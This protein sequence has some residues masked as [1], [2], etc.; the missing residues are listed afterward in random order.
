LEA[1]EAAYEQ[2]LAG[3]EL[4]ELLATA[5]ED[6]ATA[7]PENGDFGCLSPGDAYE[8]WGGSIHNTFRD[9]PVGAVSPPVP[10]GWISEEHR[11]PHALVEIVDVEPLPYDEARIA[12]RSRIYDETQAVV[13]EHL[14]ARLTEVEVELDEQLG[15]WD[16]EQLEVLTPDETK[17]DL[18]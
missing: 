14:R 2:W 12:V 8:R 3:A 1:A 5:Q 16:D 18:A 7:D 13:V 15:V 9:T 11:T 6:P 4:D 17:A 10:L